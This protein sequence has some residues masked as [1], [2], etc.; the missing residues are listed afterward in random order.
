MKQKFSTVATVSIGQ[1]LSKQA[2]RQVKQILELC[3][4]GSQQNDHSIT[5]RIKEH[6]T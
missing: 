4:G 6:T 2:V 3:G 1:T 5:L